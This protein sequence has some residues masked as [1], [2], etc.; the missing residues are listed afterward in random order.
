M[1]ESLQITGEFREGVEHRYVTAI[2]V[3]NGGFKASDA[4]VGKAFLRALEISE[5]HSETALKS[6]GAWLQ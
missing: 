3:N 6:A 2:T 5:R 1:H 4:H